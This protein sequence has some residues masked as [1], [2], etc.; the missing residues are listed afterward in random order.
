MISESAKS[1]FTKEVSE[2]NKEGIFKVYKRLVQRLSDM[3]LE[4]NP[5]FEYPNMLISTV[6][7]GDHQQIH[8]AE[9]LPSLT[10]VRKG[11]N[12]ITNFFIRMVFNTIQKK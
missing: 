7:E 9:Y 11:N 8:F 10:N 5:D 2:N 3:G 4:F 1:Y 6:I 12:G